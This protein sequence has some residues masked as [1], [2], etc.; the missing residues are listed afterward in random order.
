[1]SGLAW[2]STGDEIW[3]AAGGWRTNRALRAVDLKRRQ[4]LILQ[5]PASLTLW[6]IAPDGRVLLA[7][8]EE[9]SALVGVPPGES[10]ERDLSWFDTSGLAT[11]PKTARRSCLTTASA[12]IS[13]APM[14]R[15]P[16][17]SG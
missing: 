13:A 14:G 8:D 6:D 15:R 2:S 11:F 16:F 3:F 4:R 1:V 17:T 5:T 9:R 12:S 7:R 10:T